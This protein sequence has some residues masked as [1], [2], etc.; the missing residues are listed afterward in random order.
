MGNIILYLLP[1]VRGDRI[2]VAY[3][4]CFLGFMWLA[5]LRKSILVRWSNLMTAGAVSRQAEAYRAMTQA[6]ANWLALQN[7]RLLARLAGTMPQSG[8]TNA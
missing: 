8:L 7:T 2:G 4:A 1:I 5:T 3:L 6:I